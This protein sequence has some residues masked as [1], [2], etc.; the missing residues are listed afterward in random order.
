MPVH[1]PARVV[2]ALI[3]SPVD[4]IAPY[5]DESNRICS[6]KP[7]PAVE[8]VGSCK[9]KSAEV[10]VVDSI[11]V[12]QSIGALR[13]NA[14]KLKIVYGLLCDLLARIVTS[15]D[16]ALLV[17]IIQLLQNIEAY[18]AKYSKLEPVNTY[19]NDLQ[20]FFLEQTDELDSSKYFFAQSM[21]AAEIHMALHT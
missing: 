12:G 20:G 1:P 10:G 6:N 15:V 18:L 13:N 5:T 17:P 3:Q 9:A 14:Q 7:P 4:F 11:E 19:S 2:S 8:L 16:S 21:L